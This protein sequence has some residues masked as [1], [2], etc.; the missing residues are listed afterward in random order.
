MQK[1]AAVLQGIR[2]LLTTLSSAALI[3]V[4]RMAQDELEGTLE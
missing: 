2:S 4:Q 1:E 3:E